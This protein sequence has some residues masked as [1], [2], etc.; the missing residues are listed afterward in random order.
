LATGHKDAIRIWQ[1][2]TGKELFCIKRPGD[3][4]AY[5]EFSFVNSLAFLPDGKALATGMMDST[6]LVWDL[7]AIAKE[8]APDL[9]AKTL[10]T[11]WSELSEE[12]PKAYQAI[13]TLGD[14]PKKALPFLKERLKPVEQVDPKQIQRLLADLDSDQFATRE[15]AAKQLTKLGE[16]I[17]PALRKV[18]EGQPSEEVRTRLKAIL[19]EP[20]VPSGETLRTLR[21]IQVLERI[22][23]DDARE[24]LK[25]LA[26]GAEAARETQEAK[27]TLARL[28]RGTAPSP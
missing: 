1:V 3:L 21:A 8:A 2:A 4:H 26:T 15:D 13:W 16:R 24:V 28:T 7:S 10:A 14:S 12:A 6:V 27:D 23:T 22:G 18:L 17:H 25:K 9:D 20:A 11:L 19:E 5:G